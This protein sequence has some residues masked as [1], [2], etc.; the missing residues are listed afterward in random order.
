MLNTIKEKLSTVLYKTVIITLVLGFLIQTI[1]AFPL[2]A[3]VV[4][5]D[6][7]EHVD[8]NNT[9]E[10]NEDNI[11]LLYEIENYRTEYSKVFMRTDGKLEYAYYD[12]LVNYFDGDKYQE[13][14]A[15][16]KEEA[17]DYNSTINKYNVKLPKKISD[18]K[19][20]K[21]LFADSSI[22][23]IYDDINKS[24]ATLLENNDSD[25][26]ISNLKNVKGQVLYKNIFNNVDLKIE[27]T[28]SYF[29]ENIIVNKYIKNFSFEY[30]LKLKKLTLIEDNNTIKFVDQ[31]NKVVYEIE[32]YFMIDTNSK[33]SYEVNLKY[34]L[35]K[36]DEY[37]FT[38]I[39]DDEFLQNATYP[40]IIDPVIKYTSNSSSNSVVR[41]KSFMKDS[42][43]ILNNIRLTKYI[44]ESA[45]HYADNGYYGIMQIDFSQFTDV[46]NVHTASVVLRGSS[47]NYQ[48]KVVVRE[49][50]NNNKNNLLEYDSINGYTDYETYYKATYLENI[51][52]Y[53]YEFDIREYFNNTTER[54]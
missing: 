31:N 33:M 30:T 22:E 4:N 11:R 25:G 48:D 20:I 38:I 23:L 24:S 15:S 36:E 26:N 47:N 34:E 13:V 16:F 46:L 10:V 35:I 1:A 49:I 6:E 3:F 2:Y 21:L 37:K 44:A 32:P 9:N 50:E 41:A 29:K 51:G 14:D 27:S 54:K 45:E 43:T 7:I 52:N 28:G 18:N 39:P 42:T 40:V 8:L 12:E 17:N 53:Y 19:K 5:E